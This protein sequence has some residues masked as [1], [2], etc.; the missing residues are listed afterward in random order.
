[1]A[2]K[3]IFAGTAEIGVPL[4]KTLANDNRFNIPLVVTQQ[5]RPGGR[6]MEFIPS[7]V[8]KSALELELNIFQQDVFLF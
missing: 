3:I 5:D 4:L 2:I 6:K 7:P 8:K 1:M